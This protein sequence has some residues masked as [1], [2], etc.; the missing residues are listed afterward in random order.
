MRSEAARRTRRRILEAATAAFLERGYATTS[1]R[2][3]AA[4][5]GVSVPAVEQAFGTKARLL[6]AAIDVAIA[7]DHEDVPVRER[8]WVAVGTAVEAVAAFVAAAQHRSAGLV[9]A[10]FEGANSDPTLAELADELVEQR[11]RTASWLVEVLTGGPAD[12][13]DVDTLWALME[14]AVFDRLVR[15]KGWSVPRYRDWFAATV[16]RLLIGG[17]R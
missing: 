17:D 3:V 4:A 10:V 6:K 14:P 16:R 8:G 7:G 2:A 15:R 5:A 11:V 9:L 12:E 1:I 13:H